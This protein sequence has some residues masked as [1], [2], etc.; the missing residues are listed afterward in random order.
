MAAGESLRGEAAR[1]GVSVYA[2]RVERA[3]ERGYSSYRQQ[4]G[5]RQQLRD[6]QS[7]PAGMQSITAAQ[8]DPDWMRAMPAPTRFGDT[9][10]GVW[11]Y[12]RMAEFNRQ[13]GVVRVEF[14][15]GGIG[16]YQ[17]VSLDSW[18]QYLR[19]R[20]SYVFIRDFDGFGPW[21]REVPASLMEIED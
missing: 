4:R 7:H 5:H 16:Y 18:K 14:R 20:S 17:N 15:D 8:V 13:A 6:Y 21:S 3:R 11:P 19:Q 9:P 2:V 10:T 1:R 12:V